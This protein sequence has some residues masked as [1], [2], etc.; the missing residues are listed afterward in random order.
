MTR[1][2]IPINHW[3]SFKKRDGDITGQRT[4]VYFC[5]H[6]VKD[7]NWIFEKPLLQSCFWES[8][9]VLSLGWPW[10]QDAFPPRGNRTDTF[11]NLGD[12]R[13]AATL[14]GW[15]PGYGMHVVWSQ[16]MVHIWML[17]SPPPFHQCGNWGLPA[18]SHD[19]D[20]ALGEWWIWDSWASDLMP[21]GQSPLYQI[22]GSQLPCRWYPYLWRTLSLWGR[23]TWE[24]S[25][26][27][28]KKYQSRR[29]HLGKIWS[30]CLNEH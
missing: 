1:K 28:D 24:G 23:G 15:P 9:Q 5:F 21:L 25:V 14:R 13:Q 20:H 6:L 30:D 26:L 10:V 7:G 8:L 12:S 27:S 29:C 3:H 4:R 18:W 16:H 19:P 2:Q 11:Q 17:C 22:E